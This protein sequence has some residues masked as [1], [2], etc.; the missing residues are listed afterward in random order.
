MFLE[1]AGRDAYPSLKAKSCRPF[2]KPSLLLTS[3]RSGRNRWASG[4]HTSGSVW[5]TLTGMAKSVPL[6]MMRWR[7]EVPGIGSDRG[8]LIVSAA[9]KFFLRRELTFGRKRNLPRDGS[10]ESLDAD[11]GSP[12]GW[13]RGGGIYCSNH[14]ETGPQE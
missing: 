8:T 1:S 12:A 7:S 2:G 10:L 6:G 3:Q 13:H 11:G 5:T 4:P 9:S 14:P